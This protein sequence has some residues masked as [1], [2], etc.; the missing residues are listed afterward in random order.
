MLENFIF[1]LIMF[2]IIPIMIVRFI[3]IAYLIKVH[4]C[5]RERK[6]RKQRIRMK[7][8]VIVVTRCELSHDT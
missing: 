2:D 1:I 3:S 7:E 5:D 4:I 8:T 6:G